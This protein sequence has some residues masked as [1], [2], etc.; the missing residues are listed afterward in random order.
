M[1]DQ[2]I[3]IEDIRPIFVGNGIEQQAPQMA[4]MR[5]FRVEIGGL[6]HY[7]SE[8]GETFKSLTTFLSAVK[9]E[10]KR[11][12]T[13]RD[14]MADELG[15]TK[16]VDEY[17]EATADYGT[18]LHIAIAEFA[19]H[20]VINWDEF[21]DWAFAHLHSTGLQGNTLIMAID[22]LIC[23]T[24][25]M[26][27]F[28]H[29]YKVKVLAVEVPV[30]HREGYATLVDLV[31]QM[32]TNTRDIEM[33]AGLGRKTAIINLK[34][35]RKGFFESH[36][37]QLIGELRA[38]SQTYP[39]IHVTDILN[40]APENWELKP[41]YK[42]KSWTVQADKDNLNTLFDLYLE[43]G[44]ARGVLGEPKYTTTLLSGE[45]KF[46]DSPLQNIKMLQY[47]DMVRQEVESLISKKK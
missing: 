40:L 18:A 41:A 9:A 15:S 17:V 36:G 10:E 31:V 46:G 33:S 5:V 43:I 14:S 7:R 30:F 4:T 6:R 37:L 2:K 29:D 13:W 19:R 20:G 3:Q 45:T 27:Q 35:G 1:E 25:A 44:K 28:F 8:T 38:F 21:K 32:D 47:G 39:G 34:S 11:L 22:S 26:A 12:K 42:I 24:A 16:K 23:D